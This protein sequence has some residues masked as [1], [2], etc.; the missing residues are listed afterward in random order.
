MP[1]RDQVL[2]I[3][4]FSEKQKI[5]FNLIILAL[6]IL[7]ALIAITLGV[8]SISV[9]DVYHT[10]LAHIFA[11]QPGSGLPRLYDTIIW[12]MRLPRILLAI[13][14]GVALATA[15]AVYQGCFRNPLV[16]PFIL[17]VSSG[18]AFGAGLGIVFP[19]FF[20]SIQ[21]SAFIFGAIAVVIAYYLASL[22]GK[23]AIVPLILAGVIIG[24]IFDGLVSILKYIATEAALRTIV[25]WIMGGFY[26]ASWHDVI[27]NA[28]TILPSAL[29]LIALG[30]KLNVLSLGDE[31]ARSLGVHPDRFKV[32]VIALATLMTAVAVSTVGIIAWVGLMMPHATRLLLGPDHRYVLP[33]AGLLGGIYLII[34]DT[35]ARTLLMAEIPVG[36]ITS[37]LGAPYLFYLIRTRGR[38]IME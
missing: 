28:I 23:V 20:L 21:L 3:D 37:M 24:S 8:Y 9:I 22:N 27:V 14:V 5:F 19:R 16:E 7:T 33:A 36:I 11:L 38:Y 25:F 12:N 29:I 15:G 4:I 13:L 1:E 26:Y 30:W 31:E 35:L 2:P 18:A 6:L 10:I 17:G 32:I 34:C